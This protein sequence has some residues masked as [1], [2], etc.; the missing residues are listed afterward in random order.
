MENSEP[1]HFEEKN[2]K[3]FERH[4]ELLKEKISAI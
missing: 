1:E 3:K 4:V 2:P